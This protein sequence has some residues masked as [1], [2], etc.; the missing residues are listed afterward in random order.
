MFKS[1]EYT[2]LDSLNW[3]KRASPSAEIPLL[4]LQK[5]VID[6]QFFRLAA[7]LNKFN[8]LRKKLF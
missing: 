8:F 2:S 1:Q 4:V 5:L 3:P 7:Y 6:K